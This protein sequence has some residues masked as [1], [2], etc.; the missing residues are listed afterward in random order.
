MILVKD[1]TKKFIDSEK[2]LLVL[3]KINF[4]IK[5][6]EF[7]SIVGPV[8]CGKTTLLNIIGGLEDA[9]A[10]KV[11][12]NGEEIKSPRLDVGIIFQGSL[13]FPWKTVLDNVKLS[14]KHKFHTKKEI[15]H[16]A[17]KSLEKV[18]MLKFANLYPKQLSGGMKQKTAFARILASDYRILL[19]DEPF[20]HL[21]A[22]TRLL[23]QEELLKI[24]Q[25]SK[26]TTLFVTHSIEEA[27]FLSDK[28][29]ILSALPT[30][31]LKIIDINL[32]QPRAQ[33]IWSTERFSEIRK[34]IWGMIKREVVNL[35]SSGI[36]S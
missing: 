35:N 2:E 33:E 20:S 11:F 6:N 1:L 7:V 32:I 34:E 9:T 18:G 31:V 5:E 36:Q 30:Q 24:R 8:G 23:M 3:N 10:G 16:L 26:A 12:I 4:E 13:L 21:D 29:I 25:T 22:Q 14:I 15:N 27:I 28:I 19:M 17:K